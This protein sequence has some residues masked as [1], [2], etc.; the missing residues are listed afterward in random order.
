MFI[1][2]NGHTIKNNLAVWSHWWTPLFPV[3]RLKLNHLSYKNSTP[4]KLFCF[5]P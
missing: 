1:A 4:Y 5:D 3:M 2:A